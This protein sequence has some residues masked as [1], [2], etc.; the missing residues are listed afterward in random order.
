LQ[1]ELKINENTDEEYI[2]NIPKDIASEFNNFFVNIGPSLASKLAN[3]QESYR[4]YA[5]A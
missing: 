3:S 1:E 4:G 2:S 5:N